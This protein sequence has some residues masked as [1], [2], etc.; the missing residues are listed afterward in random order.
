MLDKNSRGL[1]LE[2]DELLGW[3]LSFNQYKKNGGSDRQ[4]WLSIWSG[5]DF[6]VDRKSDGYS[7][8]VHNP[9]VGVTG[10]IQ[11]DRLR[12]LRDGAEDGLIDRFLFFYPETTAR[13]IRDMAFPQ[14]H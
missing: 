3:L 4:M 6:T 13:P 8:F 12:A 11:P 14:E 5:S 9:F 1:L 7:L 2:R 10:G